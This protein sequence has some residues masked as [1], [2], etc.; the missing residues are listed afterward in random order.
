MNCKGCFSNW[1]SCSFLVFNID[2][3]T[4]KTP[5]IIDS[6]SAPPPSWLLIRWPLL[7][8]WPLSIISPSLLDSIIITPLSLLGD[9]DECILKDH[10]MEE[11]D[12]ALLPK[13]AWE[14]L[15]SWYSLTPGSRPIC[16]YTYMYMY[17]HVFKE[18]SGTS[19][20]I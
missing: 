15:V 6:G 16:R 17:M 2:T 13:S 8:M 9:N 12:Y 3:E 10:L 19:I 5:I 7:I 14:R 18:Y 11:L 20:Y 1:Y 4:Y